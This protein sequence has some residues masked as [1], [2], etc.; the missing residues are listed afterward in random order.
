M[1]GIIWALWEWRHYLLGSP[2]Q[3]IIYTD[4]LNLLYFR[5][6]QKLNDQQRRWVLELEQYDFKL[7]HLP[8]T[9]MVQSDTLSQRPGHHPSEEEPQKE[10]L[11]GPDRFISAIKIDLGGLYNA[12]LR[13]EITHNPN[14]NHE[15]KEI[16][17]IFSSPTE[18]TSYLIKKGWTR[19]P[20]NEGLLLLYQGRTYVPEDTKLR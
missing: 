2:H 8:G 4:H 14:L 3:V 13:E 20:T 6:H 19:I 15:A 18:R 10:I 17:E 12:N 5:S 9:Q 11:L 7:D 1:L 16:L